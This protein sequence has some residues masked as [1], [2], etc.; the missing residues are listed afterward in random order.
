MEKWLTHWFESAEKSEKD[1]KDAEKDIE[2]PEIPE[3][4]VKMEDAE[5]E[6]AKSNAAAKDI[7]PDFGRAEAMRLRHRLFILVGRVIIIS[8]SLT[9]T[10]N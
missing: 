8:P 7:E 6:D 1:N 5:V 9:R 4:D 3:Q 2:K 10:V